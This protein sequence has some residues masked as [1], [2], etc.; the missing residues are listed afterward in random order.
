MVTEERL[1]AAQ[2]KKLNFEI[3]EQKRSLLIAHRDKQLA[4]FMEINAKGAIAIL[5]AIFAVLVGASKVQSSSFHPAVI[6][7]VILLIVLAF[8]FLAYGAWK[9]S[10]FHTDRIRDLQNR[11]C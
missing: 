3:S 11:L 8:Y 4:T 9:F 7:V 2:L 5:G 10:K 1:R 6:A